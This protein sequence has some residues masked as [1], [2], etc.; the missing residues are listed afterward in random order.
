MSAVV[1][2]N[3]PVTCAEEAE[4]LCRALERIDVIHDTGNTVSR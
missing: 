3:H 4:T 1:W 2:P